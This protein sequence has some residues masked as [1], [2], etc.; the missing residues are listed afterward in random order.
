GGAQHRHTVSRA[1]APAGRD[2]ARS[3]VHQAIEAEQLENLPNLHRD[4]L[5]LSELVIATTTN[6]AGVDPRVMAHDA[7]LNGYAVDGFNRKDSLTGASQVLAPFAAITAF[8]ERIN[9]YT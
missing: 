7:L 9:G 6:P 2:T 5:A 3:A 4:A 1:E 8:E